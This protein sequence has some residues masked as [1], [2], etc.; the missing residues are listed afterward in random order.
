MDIPIYYVQCWPK[1]VL[2]QTREEA[3]QLMK[4]ISNYHVEDCSNYF[5][6]QGRVCL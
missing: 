6:I 5:A 3:I 4:A 2:G 1:L